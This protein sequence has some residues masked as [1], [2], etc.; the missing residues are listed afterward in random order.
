MALS[1]GSPLPA[2]SPALA[3]PSSSAVMLALMGLKVW[4]LPTQSAHRWDLGPHRALAVPAN[5]IK[6][7]PGRLA[8]VLAALKH[9][10]AAVAMAAL[11]VWKKTVR[12]AW[13]IFASKMAPGTCSPVSERAAPTWLVPSIP[14]YETTAAA[15]AVAAKAA[16]SLALMVLNS[17][18]TLSPG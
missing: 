15:M 8:S 4:Y 2:D 16:N 18:M 13:S 1:A 11:R 6:I 12:T 10:L 5:L 14:M 3:M 9:S 7:R 17:S